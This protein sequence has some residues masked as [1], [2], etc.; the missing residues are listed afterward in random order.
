M[1]NQM[2]VHE[3]TDDEVDRI[4]HALADAT[5]RVAEDDDRIAADQDRLAE[6]VPE[7]GSALRVAPAT[8]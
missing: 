8:R 1:F 3:L 4:F 6:C 5:R 7:G 2:V